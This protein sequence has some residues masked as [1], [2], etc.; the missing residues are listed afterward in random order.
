MWGQGV[1]GQAGRGQAGRGGAGP[2]GAGSGGR[3]SRG[4]DGRCPA[5]VRVCGQS[6][7]PR[8][9]SV[10]QRSRSEGAVLTSLFQETPLPLVWG[11]PA[12]L[13]PG[14]LL[15]ASLQAGGL[16]DRS[17]SRA[18]RRWGDDALR[19]ASCRVA[20]PEGGRRGPRDRQVLSAEALPRRPFLTRVSLQ[21]AGLQCRSHLEPP[22]ACLGPPPLLPSWGSLSLG[23]RPPGFP[24]CPEG[25]HPPS[26]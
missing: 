23:P 9:C 26:P 8:L 22:A 11:P 20:A 6:R 3:T 18:D 21:E 13:G 17:G 16:R 4:G 12:P 15:P 25:P 19:G 7:E 2:G 1:P 10:S 24:V 5:V 14:C